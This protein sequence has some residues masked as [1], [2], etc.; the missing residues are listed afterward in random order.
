MI[1]H[2]HQRLKSWQ[3][4]LGRRYGSDISSPAARRAAAWHFQLS[5]H[6]FLRVWWTNLAEIAPGVWRSNQPSPKRLARHAR[7]GIKTIIN[8]RGAPKESFWLFEDEACRAQGL[9]L[10]TIR[11]SARAAP[12]RDSLLELHRLFTTVP[13]PM[14]FHCKSGADRT[15]LAAALYLIWVENRPLAEAQRQLSLRYL[16]VA[17]SATGILDHFLRLYAREG[18]G[19]GI[20]LLDWITNDYDPAALTLSYQRWRADGKEGAW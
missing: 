18:E 15:G 7:D 19:R 17:Q 12:A 6:A 16:H 5:D 14:L 3:D 9:A 10:H 8:L 1:R 20:S 2:L 4:E 11:L 13:R